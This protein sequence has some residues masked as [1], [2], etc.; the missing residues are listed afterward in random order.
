MLG[1]RAAG[2]DAAVDGGVEGLD[3]AV[4][5]LR[6]AGNVFDRA[7]VVSDGGNGSGGSARSDELPAAGRQAG[8]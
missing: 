2:E 4:E 6:C 7:D 8:G 1:G 3:A 5:H